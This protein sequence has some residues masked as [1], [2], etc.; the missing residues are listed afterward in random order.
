MTY[1]ERPSPARQSV[2]RQSV[3]RRSRFDA[4]PRFAVGL[5][6]GQARDYTAAVIVERLSQQISDD[7]CRNLHQIEYHVRHIERFELG[8]RYPDIVDSISEL[9]TDPHLA[10]QARLVV[11]GTGV[12]APVVDMFLH[13][14]LKPVP[15]YITGADKIS[16][17]GRITRVPKRDLVSVLQVLFQTGRLRIATDLELASMLVT[18][19]SNFTAKITSSFNE[20]FGCW[21][22]NQHDDLVLAL[23]IACWFFERMNRIQTLRF[24]MV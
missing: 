17:L 18:E 2:V 22:E 21:R 4:G 5:D 12:G 13:R 19:L 14:G 10:G 8:T 7:R 23:S 15:I 24:G 3:V 20:A 1:I 16:R 9:L 6:L 11:D